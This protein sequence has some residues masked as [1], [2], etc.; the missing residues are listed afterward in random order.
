VSLVLP[1]SGRRCG[2]I[3]GASYAAFQISQYFPNDAPSTSG[4]FRVVR[5]AFAKRFLKRSA[6]HLSF[7]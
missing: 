3:D 2:H 7:R 5:H 1:G 6:V 4:I